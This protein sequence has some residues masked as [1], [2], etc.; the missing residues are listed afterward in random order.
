MTAR[1]LP[2]D[3]PTLTAADL[4]LR[5]WRDADLVLVDGLADAELARWLPEAGPPNTAA[6][7]AARREQWAG[8]RV[9]SFALTVAPASGPDAAGQ[10]GGPVVGQVQVHLHGDGVAHLSWGVYAPFRRRGHAR[11]AVR[12]VLRWCFT[13][14]G[15]AR[16]QAMVEPE[17]AA[18]RA[19]ALA[20]GLRPEGVLRGYETL[21]G[22]RRD[23]AV[24]ALLA[25]DLVDDE[26]ELR[27]RAVR[28][29][30]AAKRVAT[31]VLARNRRGRVLVVQTSYKTHWEV[32]GGLVEADEGLAQGA[33]REV[34][35]ELGVALPV[36]DLLVVDA[37]AAAGDH[38]DIV[39]VLFDGGVHDDDLLDQ[40]TFPDGEILAAHWADRELVR[41]CG[42]RLSTRLL[43]GMA[44]FASGRLPGPTL[45]LRDGRPDL[46]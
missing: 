6:D 45:V 46:P 9:A 10:V 37:C 28:A 23:L 17:N 14:L 32:P 20:C 30:L 43:A 13:D 19:T 31:G 22:V 38:P 21:G 29:G 7:L 26:V 1:V 15:L 12:R 25:G 3:Q 11:A 4:T 44:A 41:R 34:L 39:C 18:S 42:P 36:G 40:L 24:F 16:V 5:P 33:R 8:D 2:A 27:W 35:E